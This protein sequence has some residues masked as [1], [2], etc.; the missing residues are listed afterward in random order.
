LTYF[1]QTLTKDRPTLSSERAPSPRQDRNCQTVTKIWSWAPDGA[2]HQDGRTDWL[3]VVKWLGLGL[4]L[5]YKYRPLSGTGRSSLFA[6]W[7]VPTGT[8]LTFAWRSWGKP[9]S[10]QN[11]LSQDLNQKLP[12]YKFEV[13]I[14]DATCKKGTV[15]N[16]LTWQN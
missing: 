9:W 15:S 12:E 10:P 14:F 4:G 8:I 1:R 16:C 13:L 7:E 5:G 6:L 3:S 2:R 11:S